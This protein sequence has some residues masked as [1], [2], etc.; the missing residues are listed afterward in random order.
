L[1]V[2]VL[3]GEGVL[4]VE[5]SGADLGPGAQPKLLEDPADVG[6][7]RVLGDGELLGDVAV[8]EAPG[9]Q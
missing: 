6:R 5:E 3:V 4:F 9:Y 8:G 2:L 1:V 7:G